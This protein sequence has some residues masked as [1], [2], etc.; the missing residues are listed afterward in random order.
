MRSGFVLAVI[1]AAIALPLIGADHLPSNNA[2][3]NGIGIHWVGTDYSG[4]CPVLV[5]FKATIY[6]T[7]SPVKAQYFW[8]RSDGSGT[9]RQT[10]AIA[11]ETKP[12]SEVLRTEWPVGEPGKN[13]KASA[14][15]HVISDSGEVASEW[16]E[17]TGHC[18]K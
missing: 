18:R 11:T 2:D 10:V 16:S 8:E 3:V 7:H 12:T 13:F 17:S 5:K 6:F 1:I 9:K 15:L 4:R 14:R